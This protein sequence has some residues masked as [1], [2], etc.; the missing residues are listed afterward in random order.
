MNDILSATL[1]IKSLGTD[2]SGEFSGYGAVFHNTDVAGDRILPGAFAET[3][4]E[5][6]AMGRPLPMHLN[7]GLPELGGVRGIGV[8]KALAE[9]E[10][11]LRVEGK[12]SGMNTDAGRLLYER[13]R[14]GAIGGLSIGFKVK[15]N[16]AT[17]GRGA[18]EPR[19][20]IKAAT[21]AEVS[22]VD[23]PCN[24]SARVDNIKSA[25]AA[26]VLPTIREFEDFLRERGFSRSQATQIAERGFKSLDCRDGGDGEAM[27]PEA[28]AVLSDIRATLA[29][30]S[31]PS[32]R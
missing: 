30:F 29:G 25:L 32:Y 8:W 19:R 18:G 11:G 15:G 21:L 24:A 9:D 28:K 22:L 27:P 14:D 20:T 4:A 2:A 5:R 23:D 31:L 10:R 16:G 7:H 26:G 13:V 3:I 17:Y 6:K 12:I 1:E